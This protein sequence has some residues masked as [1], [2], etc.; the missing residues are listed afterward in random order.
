[1]IT[2]SGFWE[3]F[4]RIRG[5]QILQYRLSNKSTNPGDRVLLLVTG[6]EDVMHPSKD[7]CWS[8]TIWMVHLAFMVP[9]VQGRV[10]S[11]QN[12]ISMS[13]CFH[14]LV[15]NS[16]VW[17]VYHIVSKPRGAT[18]RDFRERLSNRPGQGLRRQWE[19]LGYK[20]GKTNIRFLLTPIVKSAT[21]S[22]SI[23]NFCYT[24]LT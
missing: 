22:S 10:I 18:L 19:K 11:K 23:I 3:K 7:V 17:S 4:I 24:E 14:S 13:A 12:S 16:V 20:I 1:M 9:T 5:G 6:N 2:T 8:L 21:L 15:W